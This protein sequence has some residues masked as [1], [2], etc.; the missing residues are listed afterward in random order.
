VVGF[1][2]APGELLKAVPGVLD[3][4]WGK[5]DAYTPYPVHGLDKAL[6]LRQS[7]LGGMVLVMGALGALTALLFQWWMS[8]VDYPIITGGKPPFSWQ[9]FV[10]IMFEVMVFF[11]TFTAGLGM[12]F[13]LNRLP[14]L[15]SPLLASGKM[16]MVTRDRFALAVEAEDGVLDVSAAEAALRNA[17]AASVEIIETLPDPPRASL[18]LLVRLGLAGAA[19]CLLAAGP[20]YW[21]IKLFPKIPPMTRLKETSR[22]DAFEASGFF[23]DGRSMR[24]P[25]EGSVARGRMPYLI[26]DEKQAG[27]LVNPLGSSEQVFAK[28]RGLFE[29]HCLVCHGALGDGVPTLTKAYG[30][31]PAD[32]HSTRVREL[33]D[34]ALFH[35]M[36]A[37]KN[38]MPAYGADID[39]KGRW[40]VAR[41]VRALQRARRAKEGDIP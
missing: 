40:A 25:P 32:L 38:T 28:G 22:A 19:A 14:R 36:T 16:R 34:G 31:K 35:I 6:K 11:A 3:K 39:E 30:A 26:T 4:G 5:V 2:D 21:T 9:A 12:L 8:A 33:S 1:F 27:A 7:P 41:Y 10:P 23:A 24:P 18:T 29:T 13:L 17:G 37:G 15:R 20:V